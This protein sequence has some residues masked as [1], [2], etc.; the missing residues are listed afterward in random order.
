MTPRRRLATGSMGRN[1]TGRD[2]MEE[3]ELNPPDTKCEYCGAPLPTEDEGYKSQLTNRW[4]CQ[5][6]MSD[7]LDYQ[8]PDD[9][10][11]EQ[12]D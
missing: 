8:D 5:E 4:M 7:Y 1:E 6:C 9:E 3:P 11:D 12:D 10:C 2:D